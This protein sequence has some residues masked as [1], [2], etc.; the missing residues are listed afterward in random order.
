MSTAINCSIMNMVLADLLITLVYMPRMIARILFSLEWLVEGALGLVLC[1]F[2]SMSQEISICV[3]ILTVVLIA[4]ERFFAV[5]VPLRVVISKKLSTLLLCGTWLVSLAARSPMFYGVK[6]IRF[7]SGELG[8]FWISSLSFQTERSRKSYHKSMLVA[9][10]GLPLLII[11]TLYTVI[12]VFLRRRHGLIHNV[13]GDCVSATTRK[14][15]NMILAVITAFL[16]CWMLY[17]NVRFSSCGF[18]L[19]S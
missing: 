1:I 17:F 18:F 2:V 10:Y 12:A 15:N 14:V 5:T 13:T 9:F 6:T 7:Q 4:F 19:V 3:S 11:I 16:L 8:C